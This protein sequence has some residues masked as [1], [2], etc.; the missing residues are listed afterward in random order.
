MTRKK[1]ARAFLVFLK[2]PRNNALKKGDVVE[3]GV[4]VVIS[5]KSQSRKIR[6]R[7]KDLQKSFMENRTRFGFVYNTDEITANGSGSHWT[8][9]LYI[10]SK[11]KLYYF[12][13][14][15]KPPTDRI[16]TDIKI[17]QKA[18][19]SSFNLPLPPELVINRIPMQSDPT[20]CGIWTI[21]FLHEGLSL[22]RSGK[23]SRVSS[24]GIVFAVQAA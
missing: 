24:S 5:T 8:S 14:F 2:E 7:T 13:S 20:E 3:L 18:I 4:D 9:M 1:E 19:Q 21:W 16:R 15:G 10:K 11:N 23:R 6:I 12:D 17:W 22:G